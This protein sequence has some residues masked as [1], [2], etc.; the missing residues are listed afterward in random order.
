LILIPSKAP[1]EHLVGELARVA[2][3]PLY[4]ARLFLASGRPR[5]FRYLDDEAEARRWSEELSRVKLPHYVVPEASVVALPVVRASRLE[6]RE[7]HFEIGLDGN[8][9]KERAPLSLPYTE[10]LLFVR[11]EISRERQDEKRLGTMRNVSRRLTSGLR[12]H[13][14]SREAPFALEIDPEHFDFQLLD[15]ER[16]SSTILNFEKL[17]ARIA[18]RTP[19]VE[20]DRGFDLEPVLVS[21]VKEG[22]DVTDA[23]A[24]A[25]RG[26]AGALYDNETSFRYYS[27]WRYRVA[28]HLLRAGSSE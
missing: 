4:D 15:A 17:L 21:R 10:V 2:E 5:L 26:T 3:I 14:Y 18:S 23:L 13:V 7:R 24:Q 20:L 28:R 9:M 16:G 12:L 11:G 1:E 6:L 27:R 22:A 25:E 19:S 8:E